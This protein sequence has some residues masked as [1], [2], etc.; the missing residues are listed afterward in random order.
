MKLQ[1]WVQKLMI[2][3][4]VFLLL[5]SFVALTPIQPDEPSVES[6]LWMLTLMIFIGVIGLC[7]SGAGK[8]L[9]WVIMGSFIGSLLCLCEILGLSGNLSVPGLFF[10]LYLMEFLLSIGYEICR[11]RH[12]FD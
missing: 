5:S 7:I 8:P 9:G 11:R 12:I 3:V 10:G 2:I 1:K 4:A 6:F